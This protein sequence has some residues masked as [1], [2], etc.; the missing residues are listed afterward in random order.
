MAASP[1][2]AATAPASWRSR[3]VLAL[4]LLSCLLVSTALA[5][6]SYDVDRYHR[7]VSVGSWWPHTTTTNN[8]ASTISWQVAYSIRRCRDWSG[9]VT[10]AKE[11][12]SSLGHSSCSTG[13]YSASTWVPAFSSAA[14][15]RREIVHL[16][17][18]LIR[19]FAKLSGALVDSGYATE[20][21]SFQEYSF[22]AHF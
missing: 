2:S 11:A 8:T 19:K 14:F 1:R 7:Y 5:Q 12:S 16:N 17:Y 13:S 20:R 6:Y 15:V 3:L 9:A 4:A 18:Y 21:D 22:S 10:L